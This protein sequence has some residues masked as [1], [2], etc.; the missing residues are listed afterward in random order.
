[1]FYGK[2]DGLWVPKTGQYCKDKFEGGS[3]AVLCDR[4]LE[5]VFKIIFVVFSSFH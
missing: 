4:F 5:E 1:M 2:A 3:L